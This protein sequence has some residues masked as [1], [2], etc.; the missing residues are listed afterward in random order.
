MKEKEQ[1]TREMVALFLFDTFVSL[2]PEDVL[3]GISLSG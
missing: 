1:V 2:T 3:L